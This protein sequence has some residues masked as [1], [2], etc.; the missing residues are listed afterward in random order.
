M[1]TVHFVAG[2]SILGLGQSPSAFGTTLALILTFIVILGGVA[3]V[4][5]GYIVVQV[6]NERRQNR[7]R[8]RG[9][10]DY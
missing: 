2:A 1:P 7:E 8:M 9:T 4:L 6:M 5:I 3:N 10:S